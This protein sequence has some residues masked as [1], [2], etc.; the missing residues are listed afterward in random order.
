MPKT[1]LQLERQTKNTSLLQ[2]QVCVGPALDPIIAGISTF[3]VKCKE[4]YLHVQAKTVEDSI[5][6]SKT[7][8][9]EKKTKVLK[10]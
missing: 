2:A 4:K 10:K 5:R 6:I 1:F 9:K 8:T 3:N 7:V